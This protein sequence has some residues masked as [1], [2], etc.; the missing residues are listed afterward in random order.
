[1]LSLLKILLF[2]KALSIRVNSLPQQSSC[3]GIHV[4][5]A[6]ETFAPDGFGAAGDIVN[7]ILE[8]HP[9]ATSEAIDYPAAGGDF[10]AYSVRRG[11]QAVATQVSDYAN[12]CPET[13]LVL[14][15]Y[16]QGAHIIDD[17][18]CEGGDTYMGISNITAPIPIAVG[19]HV[20]AMIWM[21]SPRH[22]PGAP[23]N[24]GTSNAPG[25]DPR[26]TGQICAPYTNII[27]SYCDDADPYCSDGDNETLHMNYGQTY[28]LAAL[29]FVN[30][31]L[32]Q[33]TRERHS[34]L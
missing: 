3:S 27:Q 13:K 10:N 33:K 28:G 29:Q 7:L 32:S 18:M 15:G 31:Q 9:S 5:G 14:V 16:S 25:F 6:R 11:A 8:A 17:A 26:L 21:G 19:S 24:V 23:Y 4:F 20:K 12:R 34:L 1:M 2:S 30:N 22:T